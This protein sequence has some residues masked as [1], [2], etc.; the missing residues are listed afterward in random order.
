MSA[1]LPGA[2]GVSPKKIFEEEMLI[3]MPTTINRKATMME[4]IFSAFPCPY[5]CSLSGGLFAIFTPNNTTMEPAISEA[6][7][8]ASASSARLPERKPPTPLRTVSNARSEEHTSEL[9]SRGHL[10]CRLLR[11]IRKHQSHM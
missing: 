9:P 6:E 4:A 5:G 10:V 1:N 3:S 7:C 8:R 11:E 2:T